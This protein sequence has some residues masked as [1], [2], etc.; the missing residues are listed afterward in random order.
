MH[1]PWLNKSLMKI[2]TYQISL[3]L[4]IFCHLSSQQVKAADFSHV[5][6]TIVPPSYFPRRGDAQSTNGSDFPSPSPSYSNPDFGVGTMIKRSSSGSPSGANIGTLSQIQKQVASLV[7]AGQLADAESL[8]RDG[9]KTYPNSAGLKSQFASI[10]ATESQQFLQEQNYDLAGKK[11]RESLVA[12]PS[13]KLAKSVDSA[14]L[15]SQ[16]LEPSLAEGHA[17][18]GDALAL[19]GRI[20]EASVEY[21]LALA[22]KPNAAAHIGLGNLAVSKGK[23]EE[24]NHHFERA[25]SIDPNSSLAYRQ[26]GALHY[27]SNDVIGAS[28]D[29]T[30]AVSLNPN[31]Q[32]AAEALVGLWKQQVAALPNSVNSHLGLGRA[33]MQTGNLE[34]AR[35]EY[36]AVV[37]ID[38][39]NPILPAARAAFKQALAKQ[40]A[41]KCVQAAKTLDSQGAWNDAHQ[42]LSEAKTYCPNDPQILLY[43]GQICERL[44][45]STEA[46]DSYM[47]VLKADPNN[48]QA[49]ERLKAMGYSNPIGEAATPGILPSS[50]SLMN[51][52][53]ATP[54]KNPIPT[55]K[56]FP[57]TNSSPP[58]N[59]FQSG[60][61]FFPPVNNF[62]PGNGFPAVNNFP[63]VNNFQPGNGFPPVNNFPPTNY[64]LAPASGFPPANTAPA[65]S[66]PMPNTPVNS[67]TIA[68]TNSAAPVPDAN[69]QNAPLKSPLTPNTQ[70]NLPFPFGNA[71]YAADQNLYIGE[72]AQVT[73]LGNFGSCV[74]ALIMA[75]KRFLQTGRNDASVNSPTNSENLSS[76]QQN[77]F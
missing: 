67:P 23:A 48:V 13:N 50:Q 32:Q 46:H 4:A 60:N 27:L 54:L 9:L 65:A 47:S 69:S 22:I 35:S 31:D 34:A 41:G 68:P 33:Y 59:S 45:L 11:A 77:Y 24:A 25:L 73:M 66:A 30:K 72:P 15:R 16:G 63:P 51:Y 49:A 26:R 19:D 8:A 7:K 52:P 62:Q 70:G 61:G 56:T 74:R 39:N 12:Q 53:S 2:Q 37:A 6:Q 42:K 28:A 44:G 14:V 10:T 21:K 18:A 40:E 64:N 3:C 58:V 43:N 29:F 55:A 76:S 71:Y 17:A 57:A 1:V 75:E 36:K 5:Q 38:P 20:L